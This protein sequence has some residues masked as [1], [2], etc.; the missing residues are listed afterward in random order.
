MGTSVKLEARVCAFHGTDGHVDG[1]ELGSGEV[2]PADLVIVGV[3]ATPR[4]AL[5]ERLGVEC[6]YGI[7]VDGHCRT[8]VPGV[9]AVGDCT[10]GGH[11][12]AP[13][14]TRLESVHNAVEQGKVAAAALVG[15]D[16]AYATPPFFWSDQGK[17]KIQLVGLTADVDRLVVRGEVGGPRVSVLAYRAG[18]LV[19]A[20]CANDPHDFMAAR[21]ALTMGRSLDP[22]LAEVEAS[23]KAC[24]VD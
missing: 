5:A 8:S 18:R 15:Q 13:P 14:S 6:D 3:G 12:V 23:L 9:L 11:V 24:F 1:V 21:R 16:D 7:F 17:L 4:T 22:D 20:D 19:G 10:Q 2:L